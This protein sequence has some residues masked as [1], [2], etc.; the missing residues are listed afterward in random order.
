[1]K[2]GINR[3][4]L[5]GDWDLKTCFRQAKEAGFDSIE[6]N[7]NE[8]DGYLSPKTTDAEAADIRKQADE[9]GIEISS[10]STGVY[11]G[12]PFTHPD[13]SVRER[14]LELGKH[15]IRLARAL[16]LD[17]I[18]VVPGAVN[19]DM[20]YDLSYNRAK[21]AMKALAVDAER[22][23]VRVGVENVWNKFLLS[24]LEMARFLD[25]VGSEWV[26]AYFDAGNVLVYGFPDQWIRILN[27]RIGRVHVKDFRNNIGN[28]QGFAN[29]LQGD[30]PWHRVKAAL[31]DIGYDGYITAEVEGYRVLPELGLR[32]IAD[33]LR[34]IFV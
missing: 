20:P 22:A 16:G 5:P 33:C 32:H 26:N 14:A 10:V 34:A 4:T 31:Q 3:W 8:S 25:E 17:A 27:K 2:I 30:L 1:M 11:W 13:P 23:K 19:N 18:L 28:I 29:P 21:E 9:V 12:V 7:M 15:Q 24:P 6:I